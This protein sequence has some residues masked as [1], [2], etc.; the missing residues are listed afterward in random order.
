M[1]LIYRNDGGV[2][3]LEVSQQVPHGSVS[4]AFFRNEIEVISLKIG[5]RSANLFALI[6]EQFLVERAA[7]HA[8]NGLKL[9]IVDNASGK[10]I[11]EPVHFEPSFFA[12]HLDLST[13]ESFPPYNYAT[14]QRPEKLA[15]FTHASNEDIFLKTFIN[16][17]SQLTDRQHIYIIDHGSDYH[18]QWL[19]AETGC[20]V[21]RIPKGKIDHLNIKR[22][23]EYF[24]RF[25]LTQY[26]W[27]LHVDSDEL[28]VHKKGPAYLCDELLN[29]YHD[30]S[31]QASIGLNLI[32]DPRTEKELNLDLPITSQRSHY[33][34][35]DGY[36]KPVLSSIPTTW[37]LGFHK[38][39]MD[40]RNVVVDDLCLVHLAFVS[41]EERVRRNRLW[42]EYTLTE[43]DS[44]FVN[45]SVRNDG[46]DQVKAE[47]MDMLSKG[48]I[49]APAWL[50]GQF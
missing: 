39:L 47:L 6:S 24:Q 15:V 1:A 19:S 38:N 41:L 34:V 36:D 2:I 16:Y 8:K 42:R 28:L 48:T 26:Q 12:P 49:V 30:V 17:Y 46:T 11:E 14:Y 13:S 3:L 22:Y 44:T 9:H 40:T 10:I 4:L 32:Q 5:F 50:S 25:L 18:S 35:A 45:Q 31:L 7:I 29:Q 43:A 37:I 27:V 23:V 21:I 33:Q 20:Q